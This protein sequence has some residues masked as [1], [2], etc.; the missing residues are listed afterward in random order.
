VTA[1]QMTTGAV[2]TRDFLS[3]VL[4]RPDRAACCSVPGIPGGVVVSEVRSD[5]GAVPQR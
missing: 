3:E 4:F 5:P 1:A 2:L